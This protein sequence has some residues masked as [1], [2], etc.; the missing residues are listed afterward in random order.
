MVFTCGSNPYYSDKQHVS[1]ISEF[2]IRRT[3]TH[4][5]GDTVVKFISDLTL[6]LGEF[7]VLPGQA[8]ARDRIK[9]IANKAASGR[10]P[11]NEPPGILGNNKDQDND[12]DT[13]AANGVKHVSQRLAKEFEDAELGEQ[14]EA[15]TRG[16]E[17]GSDVHHYH[18]LLVR[19]IRR[20]M[21]DVGQSPPKKYTYNEWAW[22]LKLMGEDEGSAKTHRTAKAQ[23]S[24]IEGQHTTGIDYDQPG[25]KSDSSESSQTAAEKESREKQQ[26]DVDEKGKWSWLGARSP[27]MGDSDEANWVLERLSATLEMELREVRDEA[28]RGSHGRPELEER[29]MGAIKSDER[30][31][32][33]GR[34]RREG[35]T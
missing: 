6:R 3:L 10:F 1:D 23:V 28:R 7:T 25:A 14:H 15:E 35:G 18:Y 19:E 2:T 22:F 12:R 4:N 27:L 31:R 21:N 5:R 17:I 30:R 24:G 32:E 34:V 11:F 20:V 26:G 8:G 33:E 9:S 13:Q 29:A 16:D